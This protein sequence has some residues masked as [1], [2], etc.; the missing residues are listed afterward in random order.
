MVQKLIKQPCASC[1]LRNTHDRCQYANGPPPSAG[2]RGPDRH[3][4]SADHRASPYPRSTE[5]SESSAAPTKRAM[6]EIAK[7]KNSI[8]HLEGHVRDLAH[9]ENDLAVEEEPA[10]PKEKENWNKLL[11]CIPPKAVVEV[12]LEYLIQEVS[13]FGDG[14]IEYD[15]ADGSV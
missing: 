8:H 2:G 13:T 12:L 5:I 15:C 9:L 3:P 10:T 1:I 7:L 14:A 11:A 6:L 4:L